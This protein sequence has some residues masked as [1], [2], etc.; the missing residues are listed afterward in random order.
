MASP[1]MRSGYLHLTESLDREPDKCTD[2]AAS[3]A[4]PSTRLSDTRKEAAHRGPHSRQVS[5]A[6]SLNDR[7]GSV[8]EY[9]YI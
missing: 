1:G 2:A 9:Q 4:V 6:G 3:Q 8:Q 5:V 7:Y